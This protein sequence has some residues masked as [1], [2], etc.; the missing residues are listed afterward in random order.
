M[1]SSKWHSWGWQN[2]RQEACAPP[3]CP[4]Q[5]PGNPTHLLGIVAV[6]VPLD[7]WVWDRLVDG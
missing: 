4:P 3:P 1:A 2:Q 5:L 7:S 6:E